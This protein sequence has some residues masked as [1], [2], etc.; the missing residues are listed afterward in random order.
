MV[1]LVPLAVDVIH[2]RLCVSTMTALILYLSCENAVVY[3]NSVIMYIGE[4]SYALYLAHLPVFS[5]VEFY[6]DF[7]YYRKFN[8]FVLC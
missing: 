8:C 5:V 1:A 7:I 6:Y 4:I 2:L 3:C